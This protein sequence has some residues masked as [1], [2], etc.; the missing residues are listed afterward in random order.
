MNLSLLDLSA[1][2]QVKTIF[3]SNYDVV[4]QGHGSVR[5]PFLPSAVVCVVRVGVEIVVIVV[6]IVIII[7]VVIVVVINSWK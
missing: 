6:I 5:L 7:V 2:P 3:R 1:S 4:L